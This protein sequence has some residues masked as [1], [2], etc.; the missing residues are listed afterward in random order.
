[1]SQF[2]IHRHQRLLDKSKGPL[3]IWPLTK[4]DNCSVMETLL[5]LNG[6]EYMNKRSENWLCQVTLV[7]QKIQDVQKC[8][9]DLD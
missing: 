6:N 7:K 5:S 4:Q 1:M 8:A 9:A 2:L 3:L